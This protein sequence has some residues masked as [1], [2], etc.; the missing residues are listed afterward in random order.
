MNCSD[1]RLESVP[2]KL[3]TEESLTVCYEDLSSLCEADEI[4]NHTA[5]LVLPNCS[6]TFCCRMREPQSVL[7]LTN[8]TNDINSICDRGSGFFSPPQR[9]YRVRGQPTILSK[10]TRSSKLT[11]HPF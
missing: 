5:V 11:T 6:H 10:D 7:L 1:V 2:W 4:L 3:V 8:G 9:T